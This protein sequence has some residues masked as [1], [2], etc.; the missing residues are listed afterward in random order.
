MKILSWNV[1]GLRSVYRKNFSAWLEAC[2]ADII[3]L[4]ET[5]A[6]R[7]Q[8][9]QDLFSWATYRLYSNH[10]VKLGY[11][12]VAVFTKEE[13]AVASYELGLDR[14]DEEGRMIR[15]DYANF[16][17][18]NLYIPHGGRAKENLEYKLTVYEK[19]FEY[20]GRI[21]NPNIFL[22]GDFNIAREDIDLAYPNENR[23]N[24]M[25]T[26]EEREKLD[27]LIALGFTDTFR[28]FHPEGG[29]YSWWPYM[30]NARARN[31]GWRIDYV[32]ASSSLLPRITSACIE[33]ETP[34][35]DHC[36][37]GIELTAGVFGGTRKAAARVV[38][39][40]ATAAHG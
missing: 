35:S 36:P 24:V 9:P 33:K 19:L 17:I 10:A 4:Q 29:N 18:L 31:I 11:S 16:T 22:A 23:S 28:A 34:G 2:E 37:V 32:F 12:G 1:N 8:F 3:C 5:K 13:P 20:I 15:L 7:E 14:F 21:R 38:A 26:A 27:R 40:K 30:A 25:F 6:Q 39:S